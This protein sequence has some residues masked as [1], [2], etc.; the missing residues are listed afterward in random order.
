MKFRGQ[1]TVFLSLILLCMFS[2]I[3]SLI[4]SAR[5]F[6]AR[7]YL[8]MAAYSALDSVMSQYHLP[9]WEDYRV[10]G[11]EYTEEQAVEA[12]FSRYLKEYL[13][14]P[15]WYTM[16]LDSVKIR[17]L[18]HLTDG[19]GKYLEQQILD[20]MKYGIWSLDA[21]QNEV[22]KFNKAV[23]EAKGVNEVSKRMEAQTKEAW[24]LEGTLEKIAKCLDKQEICF[25]E[26]KEA[27]E[28][29]DGAVFLRKAE[30]L[31]RNLGKIPGLVKAYSRQAD[32]LEKKMEEVRKEYE[33]KRQEL[34]ES[35]Q[36]IMLEQLSRYDAYISQDGERRQEVEQLPG[37]AG[38]QEELVH[39]VMEEAEEIMEYVES[40]EPEQ[41]GEVLEEEDLWE[42]VRSHF[43]QYRI[44]RVSC[45]SGSRDK[46]S[47]G[48]LNQIRRAAESGIVQLVLPEGAKVSDGIIETAGLPSRN[49]TKGKTEGP[50]GINGLADKALTAEYMEQFFTDFCDQSQK[51]FQYEIEYILYGNPIDG[52][53]LSSSIEQLLAVREGINLIN[54]LTDNQKRREA[55]AL[56]SAIV[57][58]SGFAPLIGITAFF[59]M[60]IWALGESLADVKQ[61]LSGGN[62]PM[63]KGTD[64]W[65]LDLEGLLQLGKSGRVPQKE[66][67]E[68]LDYTD[69]LKLFFIA[70]PAETVIY[71][72]MDMMQV[73]I[74]R[75]EPGFS[76]RQCASQVEIETVV[77][78]KHVFLSLGLL[79]SFMGNEPGR[80]KDSVTV[81]NAY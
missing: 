4:E 81:K 5:I 31:R 47:E 40:W 74:I 73:T 46:E 1:I 77:C 48:L 15:N 14:T 21:D 25:Q 41:E 61:L 33:E 23:K 65:T 20:F 63:W 51:E 39:Q 37:I 36:Q 7:C 57:G 18:V 53:N 49:Q 70:V 64:E 52:S 22:E 2:L 79:K 30:E 32:K 71:R 12:E 56:A 69:Y 10:L 50:Q 42:G 35:V 58:V 54:I 34:G 6:G 78:G 9:L 72:M 3:C 44:L 75:K 24:K 66:G 76:I 62:V 17:D 60:G 45:S 28:R 16:T 59:I 13:N 67:G 29:G 8:E 26:G 11:V 80:Y 38:E 27:L 55:E 68:G 43:A 19:G